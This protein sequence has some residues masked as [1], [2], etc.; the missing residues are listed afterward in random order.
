MKWQ[1]MHTS[2]IFECF[3]MFRLS[4]SFERTW[5]RCTVCCQILI[6]QC[7]VHVLNV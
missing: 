7:E 5:K 3:I 1:M 6:I 2:C 4:E